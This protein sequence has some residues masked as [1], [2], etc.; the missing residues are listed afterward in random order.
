L[1]VSSL[2]R[3]DPVCRFTINTIVGPIPA[4][5]GGTDSDTVDYIA[6][7]GISPLA[8]GNLAAS[9]RPAEGHGPIPARAGEPSRS[10]A[11]PLSSRAYPRSRGGN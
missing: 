10:P 11:V 4:L 1:G 5:R 8:R 9:G 3:G 6:W 2:A 7:K